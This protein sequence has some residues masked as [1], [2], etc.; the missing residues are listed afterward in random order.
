MIE[1]LSLGRGDPK[2][3]SKEL[4]KDNDLWAY[5][6]VGVRVGVGGASKVHVYIC[7]LVAFCRTLSEKRTSRI[8]LLMNESLKTQFQLIA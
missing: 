2:S 5:T 1:S 3:I 7:F 6:I 8:T 4:E